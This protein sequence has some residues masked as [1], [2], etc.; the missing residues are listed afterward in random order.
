MGQASELLQDLFLRHWKIVVY[1]F[2][3]FLLAVWQNWS[4]LTL[5]LSAIAEIAVFLI[6]FAFIASRE[7]KLHWQHDGQQSLFDSSGENPQI[8]PVIIVISAVLLGLLFVVFAS[9]LFDA[10]GINYLGVLAA[11]LG[12]FASLLF[13][14]NSL[15]SVLEAMGAPMFVLGLLFFIAMRGMIRTS[16]GNSHFQ[17]MLVEYFAAK[18]FAEY[19]LSRISDIP[20]VKSLNNRNAQQGQSGSLQQLQGEA[21]SQVLGTSFGLIFGLIFGLVVLA[22]VLVFLL[23]PLILKESAILLGASNSEANNLVQYGYA[24]LFV[25]MLFFG[26]WKSQELKRVKRK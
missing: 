5:V 19:V 23:P 18:L 9:G 10:Y 16:F 20:L 13:R 1:N 26:F 21:K 14:E 2:A 3:L 8:I 15:L 7:G 17:D 22:I 12:A 4:P 25:L 11:A 24:A 6:A